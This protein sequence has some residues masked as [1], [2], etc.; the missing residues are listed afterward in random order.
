MVK[1]YIYRCVH[2]AVIMVPSMWRFSS[3]SPSKKVCTAVIENIID[4]TQFNEELIIS[5]K[6]HA[7]QTCTRPL[8]ADDNGELVWNNLIYMY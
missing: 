3:S 2:T 5:F 8:L 7:D 1:F 6:R 4:T